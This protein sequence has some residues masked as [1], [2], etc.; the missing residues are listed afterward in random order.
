MRRVLVL[1]GTGML[2]Q[3]VTSE[4]SKSPSLAV[5]ATRRRPASDPFLFDVESGV[6]RLDDLLT[7]GGGAEYVVNCIAVL[8]PGIDKRDSASV[9]R[10]VVVNALFPHQLASAAAKHGARVIHVSTDGVFSGGSAQPYDEGAG[11]DCLDVYGKTKALGEVPGPHWLNIRCS[12]VGPDPEGRKG[13]LEWFLSRPK[14]SELSGYTDQMW[15]GVTTRQFAELCGKLIAENRF[16]AVAE[17]STVHHWCPNRAVSKFELLE[18]F[19]EV[20]GRE[21]TITPAR[22]LGSSAGRILATRYAGLRGLM[23]EG[24]DIRDA[25]VQLLH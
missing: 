10:A 15:T 24:L 3:M 22:L 4:L 21:V 20:T 16:D 17:E 12:I 9:R 6:D 2:G 13:L 1:G 19:K 7:R 14:G 25:I 23:G 18:I 11:T 8:K 5:T